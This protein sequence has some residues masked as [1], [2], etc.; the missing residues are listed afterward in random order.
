M[1]ASPILFFRSE[2]RF[3]S[4][5]FHHGPSVTVEHLFQARKMARSIDHDLIMQAPSATEAKRLGRKL[6]MRADWEE[7]KDLVMYQA[8][9]E[10]FSDPGLR[11][12]LLATGDAYL[13][14]GNTWC[15]AYWGVCHCPKHKVLVPATNASP[16]LSHGTGTNHLGTLLMLLR[17]NLHTT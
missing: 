14:E 4:N 7:T 2:N 11:Q 3:L 17:K 9:E 8:L 6:T 15:D 12:K 10:K 1:T 5:F 16:T 13:E